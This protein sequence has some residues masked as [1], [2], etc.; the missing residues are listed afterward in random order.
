MWLCRS[1]VPTGANP[2]TVVAADLTGDGKLDL[3][4]A[5]SGYDSI[6][7]FLGNGD[8][9]FKPPQTFA[10]NYSPTSIVVTDLTHDGHMDIVTA[11]S[12]SDQ[13]SVLLGN[14]DGTFQNYTTVQLNS[15]EY[16]TR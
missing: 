4:E 1:D 6:N 14:G 7:V 15:G 9:T 3:I 10:T 5:N 13:L 12:S 2:Y 11:S 8:G 16:P